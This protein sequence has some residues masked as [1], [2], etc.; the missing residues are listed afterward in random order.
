MRGQNISL[1]VVLESSLVVL[2]ALGHVDG[3]G[4]RQKD[5]ASRSSSSRGVSE[6][7]HRGDIGTGGVDGGSQNRRGGQQK[8]KRKVH[9]G[10]GRAGSVMSFLGTLPPSRPPTLYISAVGV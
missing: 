6:R 8:A 4:D 3:A 1:V 9:V 2:G 10:Y 5:G 7:S